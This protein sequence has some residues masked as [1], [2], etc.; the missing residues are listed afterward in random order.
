MIFKAYRL[1]ALKLF[2]IF[3]AL[4]FLSISN[5]A[6]SAVNKQAT[7]SKS[8]SNNNTTKAKTSAQKKAAAKKKKS[9]KKS[10]AKKKK[11]N[12]KSAAKKKKSNKK[13]AAKKKK[14]N[15]K[16]AAKKK[17]SNKKSAAKK[18]DPDNYV[19]INPTRDLGIE[20]GYICF[21]VKAY[22]NTQTSTFSKPVCGY[23]PT[24]INEFKLTWS[25]SSSSVNGYHVYFGKSVNKTNT[26]L[27][28]VR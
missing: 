23:I 11:S 19:S 12:K 10:A 15:K 16:S 17:K 18:S 7:S 25:K 5:P 13:S 24:T 1:L 21:R 20:N 9:N 28:D 3:I 26:L 4:I 14:S 22:T 8:V 6:Y 27:A 2:F